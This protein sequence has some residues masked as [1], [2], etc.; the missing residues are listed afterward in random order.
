[1]NLLRFYYNEFQKTERTFQEGNLDLAADSCCQLI[2]AYQCPRLIQV[3]AYQLR[4]LCTTNYWLAKSR[5]Q[6]ASD[7]IASLNDD[8]DELVA[9][10]KTH[11][12]SQLLA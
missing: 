10:A 7:L 3:Q 4:S 9:K 2:N 1:M 11:T 8:E 12:V 6:S 5:L